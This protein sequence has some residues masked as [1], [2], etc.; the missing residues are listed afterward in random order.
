MRLCLLDIQAGGVYG[1]DEEVKLVIAI[2]GF[3]ATLLVSLDPF[4]F[5]SS[6]EL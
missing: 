5:P 3:V 1:V 4:P 2:R 6:F